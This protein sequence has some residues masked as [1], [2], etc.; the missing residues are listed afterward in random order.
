MKFSGH[1]PLHEDTSAIDLGPDR[2][3][4]LAGH[5]PKVGHN[6]FDCSIDLKCKGHV[7]LY[8][9]LRLIRLY[10]ALRL[11]NFCGNSSIRLKD[12]PV[13]GFWIWRAKTG[14]NII[15]S[16]QNFQGIFHYMRT[17]APWISAE[18]F[19]D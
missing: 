13:N 14:V 10:D 6:E 7:R 15:R 9:A 12:Y 2:S 3:I 16:Q 17:R 1:L 8:E 11:I 18:G 5:A 19:H 4:P